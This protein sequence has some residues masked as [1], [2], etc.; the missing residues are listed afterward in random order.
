MALNEQVKGCTGSEERKDCCRWSH[1]GKKLPCIGLMGS[2]ATS[3]YVQY[4][5]T[6]GMD[7]A[8]L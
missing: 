7:V 1:V 5:E 6:V 4:D 8:V 3:R 2:V